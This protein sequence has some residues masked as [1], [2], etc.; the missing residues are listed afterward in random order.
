MVVGRR[1][2]RVYKNLLKIDKKLVFWFVCKE[3]N[4]EFGFVEKCEVE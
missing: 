4:F 1:F 2:E 3:I